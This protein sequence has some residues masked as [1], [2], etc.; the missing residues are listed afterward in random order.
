[1]HD[2]AH[3]VNL[4]IV[5]TSSLMHLYVCSCE[6]LCHLVLAAKLPTTGGPSTSF[7][8]TPSLWSSIFERQ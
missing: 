4:L 2:A 6:A 5:T 1:M 8:V 7:L 3:S